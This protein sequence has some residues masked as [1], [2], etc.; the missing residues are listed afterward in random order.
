MLNFQYETAELIIKYLK[1]NKII[2]YSKQEGIFGNI[3]EIYFYNTKEDRNKHIEEMKTNGW[4][5]YQ[6][7]DLRESIYVDFH[8]PD[9]NICV[10]KAYFTKRIETNDFWKWYKQK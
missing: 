8:K 4:D 6:E 3:E 5:F 2:K 1:E 10:Y 9:K 7:Q